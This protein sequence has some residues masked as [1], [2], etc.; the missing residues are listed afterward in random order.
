MNAKISFD[1]NGT[2]Y[3]HSILQTL[4]RYSF[5]NETGQI[6]KTSIVTIVYLE[7]RNTK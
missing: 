1:R 6:R 2:R 4:K 3:R 5:I 7:L